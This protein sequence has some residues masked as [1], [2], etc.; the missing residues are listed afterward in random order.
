VKFLVK[1]RY[2]Y[3]AVGLIRLKKVEILIYLLLHKIKIVYLK[4]EIKALAKLK[5]SSI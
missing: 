2:I 5:E 1:Q 3:L 4:K